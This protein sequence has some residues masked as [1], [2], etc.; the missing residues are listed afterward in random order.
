MGFT[1]F[2]SS[3]T[4]NPSDYGLKVGDCIHIICVGGGGGGGGG[5]AGKAGSTSSFGSIISS[6]GG[7]S[8]TNTSGAAGPTA[9]IGSN[10]GG[11]VA[12]GYLPYGTN[13]YDVYYGG[14]G[15]NGW[16]PNGYLGAGGGTMSGLIPIERG[17]SAAF[18]SYNVGVGYLG[19]YRFTIV[20]QSASSSNQGAAQTGLSGGYGGSYSGGNNVYSVGGAGG[21]GYGAGGGGSSC[22]YQAGYYNGGNSGVINH[23]DYVLTS[24]SG[25]AV[26][27]GNGGAGG[28][29][30]SY[31]YGG[32]GA[33]GCVAI[34]W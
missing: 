9:Q 10:Q 19:E 30:N 33:R 14:N 18:P 11:G 17:S 12:R 29:T 31:M 25:I 4:F 22:I 3:G 15:G 5:T 28:G 34:Y 24:T 6:A 7:N 26:T 13:M 16:H 8:G 21:L 2:T 20:F 1:I 32:G 27:V 23:K